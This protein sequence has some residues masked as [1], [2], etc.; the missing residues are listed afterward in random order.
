MGGMSYGINESGVGLTYNVNVGK[1]IN[2]T[3]SQNNNNVYNSIDVY[4]YP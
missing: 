3:I 4:P 1:A 2:S